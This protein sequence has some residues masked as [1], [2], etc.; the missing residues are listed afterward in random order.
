MAQLKKREKEDFLRVIDTIRAGM[1][2]ADKLRREIFFGPRNIEKVR[3][4]FNHMPGYQLPK[5][6]REQ[7][8]KHY[9]TFEV[10][11]TMIRQQKEIDST[12][13]MELYNALRKNEQSSL[14]FTVLQSDKAYD[15]DRMEIL[16]AILEYNN[17]NYHRTLIQVIERESTL[18]TT[19]FWLEALERLVEYINTDNKNSQLFAEQWGGE[20]TDNLDWIMQDLEIS[21]MLLYQETGNDKFLPADAKEMFL[22]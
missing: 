22:F 13:I 7:V 11:S 6:E 12:E 10:F 20:D 1:S 19:G 2:D 8:R 3:L 21:S 14:W 4:W 5:D 18:E 17:P 15:E 16:N 9:K